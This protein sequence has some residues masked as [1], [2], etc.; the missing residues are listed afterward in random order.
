MAGPAHV[1]VRKKERAEPPPANFR[2]L[3]IEQG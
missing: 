3:G 1:A 2:F